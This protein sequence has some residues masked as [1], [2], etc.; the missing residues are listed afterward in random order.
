MAMLNSLGSDPTFL[1]NPDD[2]LEDGSSF[3][4]KV[5]RAA[6]EHTIEAKDLDGSN[7]QA[8]GLK[9]MSKW[10]R[11]FSVALA[12]QAD[13]AQWEGR[14]WPCGNRITDT[15]KLEACPGFPWR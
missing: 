9:L 14:P 2:L 1:L 13:R 3:G 6:A 15:F 8:D 7:N 11:A 5:M 10:A 12:E 4:A